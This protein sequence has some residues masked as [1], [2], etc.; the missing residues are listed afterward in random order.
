MLSLSA[1]LCVAAS[2]CC[3]LRP[4]ACAAVTIFPVWVW[5]V[6]GLL[7]A[8]LGVSRKRKRPALAVS[9]LWL[10]FLVLFAEEPASL[11]RGALRAR[12]GARSAELGEAGPLNSEPRAPGS[13]PERRDMLRVVSLNCAGGSLAAAREVGE[14]QP[15]IVLLQESPS[16]QEVEHLARELFPGEGGALWG[17]DASIL[18]RGRVVP[19]AQPADLRICCVR[20]HVRLTSGLETEVVSL[21]L[22]PAL[23]RTDLW[24]PGCWREQ[25]AN[26]QA[27]REQLRAIVWQI[28]PLPAAAPL[29]LGGDFNAPAGDAIFRLLRPR[30]HDTFRESGMGWGDTILN[31]MP[32]V[33]IDQVWASERFRALAVRARQTR[34]SDHRMVICDLTSVPVGGTK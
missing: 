28:D 18:A 1:A 30:L 12:L 14:Y 11:A 16:R 9:L 6:P 10:L 23:V 17:V 19:A 29:I 4:D 15:D 22:I 26:R 21:R 2:L 7:L 5:I 13:A 33:R 24:S 34:N 3:G 25:T 8:A 32:L 27:R 20:A 31:E